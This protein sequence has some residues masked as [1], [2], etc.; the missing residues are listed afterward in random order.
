MH[1]EFLFDIGRATNKLI[2]LW[3]DDQL[4]LMNVIANN[5]GGFY[6]N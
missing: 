2:R 6:C 1:C 5:K 4:T 3:Y